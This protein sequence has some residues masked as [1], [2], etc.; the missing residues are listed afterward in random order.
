VNTFLTG[1]A[2]MAAWAAGLFFLRFWRQ[3]GD[4][5]F[6]YFAGA[7]WIL[8]VNWVVLAVIAPAAEERHY[9]YLL[10]LAAFILIIVAI[11]DKNRQERR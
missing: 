2:A 8:S 10:R 9:F 11:V 6:A 5:L 7:F 4:R 3:T 1:G